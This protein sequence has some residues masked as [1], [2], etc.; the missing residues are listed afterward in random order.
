MARDN[1][2]YLQR[3][4]DELAAQSDYRDYLAKIRYENYAFAIGEHWIHVRSDRKEIKNEALQDSEHPWI[5]RETVNFVGSKLRTRVGKLLQNELIVKVIPATAEDADIQAAELAEQYLL[6]SYIRGQDRRKITK[7]ITGASIAGDYFWEEGWDKTTNQEYTKLWHPDRILL[8]SGIEEF[9]E[10]NW[11]L[12]KY[13][14]SKEEIKRLTGFDVPDE[15]KPDA[16]MDT[17]EAR[18]YQLLEKGS[19]YHTYNRYAVYRYWEKPNPD[20][21]EGK[22]LW[23][24]R[25]KILESSD[26][27]KKDKK[28]KSWT[29]PYSHNLLP[30]VPFQ[31][32]LLPGRFAAKSF[33][34]DFRGLNKVYNSIISQ[35]L[36]DGKKKLIGSP[37]LIPGNVDISEEGKKNMLQPGARHVFMPGPHGEQPYKLELDKMPAELIQVLPVISQGMDIS[38]S[39]RQVSE[40]GGPPDASG[41]ALS[42]RKALDDSDLIPI[43]ANHDLSLA[44]VGKLRLLNCQQFQAD[45]RFISIFGE[46]SEHKVRFFKAAKFNRD[47]DLIIHLPSFSEGKQTQRA[48]TFDMV[49][50]GILNPQDP[51]DRRTIISMLQIGPQAIRIDPTILDEENAIAEN[52]QLKVGKRVEAEKYDNHKIHLEVL[53]RLRKS[54]EIRMLPATDPR[55]QAVGAHSLQHESFQREEEERLLS[56]QMMVG[57]RGSAPK[58]LGIPSQP[59]TMSIDKGPGLGGPSAI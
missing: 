30:L 37:V 39:I 11:F 49:K 4:R 16:E 43:A 46:Y 23:M 35:V 17:L 7:A 20:T 54:P 28:E 52:A 25:D 2:F 50:L 53:D 9:D 42:I 48:I 6:Y 31:D 33:I 56:Q 19:T 14:L 24:A 29:Y 5:T 57:A 26:A 40:G 36:Q 8:P 10:V 44:A 51:R 1:D 27:K 18:L 22:I 38:S 13:Y 45:K 12:T 47:F 55:K 58:E 41:Y 3:I 15:W 21:P 59:G 32:I 34:E